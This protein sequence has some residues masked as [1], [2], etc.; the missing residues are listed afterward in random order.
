MFTFDQPNNSAH[1]AGGFP[2]GTSMLF[3]QAAAPV[4]WTKETGWSNSTILVGDTYGSGGSDNPVSWSPGVSV[5]D[6]SAHTHSGPNHTHIGSVHQH[7]MGAHNHQWYDFAPTEKWTYN[8]S[9]SKVPFSAGSSNGYPALN[10]DQQTNCLDFDGYTNNKDLGNTLDGGG[11]S[12]TGYS[13]TGN[14]GSAGP[15]THSVTQETYTP[16]YQIMIAATK[17]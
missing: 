5:D 7:I 15:T 8:S 11:T 10:T 17:D 4:G 12:N 1:G 3:N 14:T 13:G 16:K 9:G 2:S 6:H